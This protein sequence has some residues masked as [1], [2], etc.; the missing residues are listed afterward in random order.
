MLSAASLRAAFAAREISPV[1]VIDAFDPLP[2]YGAFITLTLE[3]AR[4]EAK[5]AEAAYRDGTQRPLEGLTLAVKDLFDT[6]GVR[7]TYG[8]KLF[9]EHVPSADAALV[10]R[11]RDAGAIVV[12]KTLT[13]EFA[14]GITS[15]NP[16]FA[17]CRN[18]H[19][20]ARVAGGSSGGSGVALALGQAALALGT[21]TGGSIRI[22]AAFCGVSGLKPTYGLLSTDGVYPLARSL[23][24]AGPMA[25]TPADVKLFFEALA[26]R[27]PAKPAERIAVCP[28]LH[29]RPLEPGIQRAFD[30]AVSSFGTFEVPFEHAGRLYPTYAAIQ[31]GE[32]AQTHAQLFPK[33]RADYGQDVAARIDNALK[34]TLAEYAEAIAERERIRAAFQRIFVAADLLLTPVS[35]VPP[36]RRDEPDPQGF[37]DGVLPYTVPQDLAGLPACAVPVGFDDDGLPVAVQITGPPR[38]EGRVLAFAETLFSATASARAGSASAP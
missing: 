32:A 22:P 17:P 13:H 19:D 33:R 5:A 24:H 3:R 1:E 25:R 21:D 14:W 37:R 20:P 18:P 35:A 6:E 30:H 16:H 29:V 9:A 28:D 4:E 23:D 34:V 36:E 27:A 7:T 2:E 38:S 8:S 10:H 11:A 15:V 12:G 26:G 31:N